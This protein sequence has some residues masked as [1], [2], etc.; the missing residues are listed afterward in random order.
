MIGLWEF[1][2]MLLTHRS[3]QGGR[4]QVTR[5]RARGSEKGLLHRSAEELKVPS[6]RD[7]NSLLAE[8]EELFAM[9]CLKM[10]ASQVWV[11]EHELQV[12]ALGLGQET[13]IPGRQE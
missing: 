6:G 3:R 9:E 1:M 4:G 13:N 11:G 2:G 12:G 8:V 7:R 10:Q 5:T